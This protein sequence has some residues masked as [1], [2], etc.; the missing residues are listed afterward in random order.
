MFI[1]LLIADIC[2]SVC[3][4]VS[5][6]LYVSVC[7][8]SVDGRLHMTHQLLAAVVTHNV[9]DEASDAAND[10]KTRDWLNTVV[11]WLLSLKSRLS[12]WLS[13]INPL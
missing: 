12:D 2:L 6:C 8:C 1:N 3:L 11:E 9:Y 5:V 4:S 10:N 7:P 13:F